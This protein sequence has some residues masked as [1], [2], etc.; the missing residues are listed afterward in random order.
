MNR[1]L[2][3]R[4]WTYLSTAAVA[5][6]L[7]FCPFPSFSQIFVQNELECKFDLGTS[8][9][10][11]AVYPDRKHARYGASYTPAGRLHVLV[12]L[13]NYGQQ[14]LPGLQAWW[15]PA[16][17]NNPN[18]QLIPPSSIYDSPNALFYENPSD[19]GSFSANN[20]L[21]NVSDYY[22]TFSNPNSRFVITGEVFPHVVSVPLSTNHHHPYSIRNA[23]GAALQEM[24]NLEPNY[25]WY[26]FDLRDR[27]RQSDVFEYDN[28]LPGT[29]GEIDMTVLVFRNTG[30][31]ALTYSLNSDSL[32]SP[33]DNKTYRWGIGYSSMKPT[34]NFDNFLNTFTHEF[35]HMNYQAGHQCGANRTHGSRYQISNFYGMMDAGGTGFMTPNAWERWYRGWLSDEILVTPDSVPAAG[36]LYIL[37]DHA[38]DGAAMRIQIPHSNHSNFL[39]YMHDFLW[40]ENHKM[41]HPFDEKRKWNAPDSEPLVPG[42]YA[43]VADNA[44][45]DLDSI[46]LDFAGQYNQ[47]ASNAIH[48]LSAFGKFDFYWNGDSIPEYYS[49]SWPNPR[50]QYILNHTSPNPI[51]GT[52]PR[53]WVS[54]DLNGDGVLAHDR[55]LGRTSAGAL[56]QIENAASTINGNNIAHYRYTG[57]FTEALQPNQEFS[58]S[59]AAPILNY[60]EY[61]DR[62]GTNPAPPNFQAEQ[63]EPYY[64][65]GLQIQHQ[66]F[67]G[68]G[69]AKIFVK[70]NDYEVR[71]STRWTGEIILPDLDSTSTNE[72]MKLAP[73]KTLTLDLSGTP[74]RETIHP[75]TGTW[76]NPT[77]LTLQNGAHLRLGSGSKLIV[78]EF[79]TLKLESGSK[80]ELQAGAEVIVKNGGRLELEDGADLDVSYTGRVHILQSGS[81]YVE[82]Q[83]N[84]HLQ[85]P[86]GVL[87][88]DGAM[89][90]ADSSSF[91]IQPGP[92]GTGEVHWGVA[93]NSPAIVCG[94]NST[95]TITGV[96]VTDPIFR[97]KDNK[98]FQPGS[99]DKL[100]LEY[101]KI[102]MGNQS[103]LSV[104]G[105]DVRMKDLDIHRLNASQPWKTIYING[106]NDHILQYMEITGAETGITGRQFYGQGAILHLQDVNVSDCITGVHVFS[107]GVQMED[108]GLENNDVGLKHDLP[109]RPSRLQNVRMRYNTTYGADIVGATATYKFESC[110]NDY[111]GTDG[112]RF[113]GSANLVLNCGSVKHNASVGINVGL[114]SRVFLDNSYKKTGA[115]MTIVGN[116]VSVLLNY[117]H[118]I[119]FWKG[120]NDLMSAPWFGAQRNIWGNLNWVTANN[121][122]KQ[123]LNNHWNNRTTPCLGEAPIH[124][125]DNIL[126]SANN[127]TIYISDPARHCPPSFCSSGLPGDGQTETFKLAGPPPQGV[128]IQTA[129]FNKVSLPDAVR[130][131]IN[132]M[133]EFT[134]KDD[135]L[136]LAKF[137]E[138]LTYPVPNPTDEEIHFR[139]LAMGHMQSCLQ[140]ALLSGKIPGEKASNDPQLQPWVG[141]VVNAQNAFAASQ[142]EPYM[143]ALCD[144]DLALSYHKVGRNDMSLPKLNAISGVDPN[145]GMTAD[146]QAMLNYSIC[147]IKAQ[148]KVLEGQIDLKDFEAEVAACSGTMKSDQ[149]ELATVEARIRAA[150]GEASDPGAAKLQLYPTPANAQ[151]QFEMSGIRNETSTIRVFNLQGNQLIE[152]TIDPGSRSGSLSL[153]GIPSGLYLMQWQSKDQII[154]QKFEIQ[155]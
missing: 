59:G 130:D 105:A 75:L 23:G 93:A 48:A 85:G 152:Q 67:D 40:L 89:E 41:V 34:N 84:I 31:F 103:W 79:S 56:D 140:N 37:K 10:A 18:P 113:S 55:D 70:Y 99:L 4:L 17:S 123:G 97:I 78:D 53:Q 62:S 30:A 60:P 8:A 134:G 5:F 146:I 88:I 33:L 98:A 65:N 52:T 153:E 21:G 86:G 122:G 68:N 132:D 121:W 148:N 109:T 58:L 38:L 150:E 119:H 1:Q 129:H 145:Y 127:N 3:C 11:T 35:G 50:Y 92:Y 72:Y 100:V 27:K 95:F 44:I 142:Q 49:Q 101:G 16:D 76:A 19:C 155:K 108:C 112:L 69:N 28:T 13:V 90:I 14:D 124:G 36:R 143:Q 147:Q 42:I 74:N 106:Q 154:T 77:R 45:M 7:V 26:K 12:V 96:N 2:D 71:N 107:K 144:M 141:S 54:Q 126:L 82:G 114:N 9:S 137:E 120:Y 61:Y 128:L 73:Y 117:A 20:G 46:P 118:D 24:A 116:Q 110:S 139:D 115:R 111:N 91:V 131:A 51:S 136:A 87:E 133:E 80:L 32:V 104:G 29:D 57:S 6:I 149:N 47:H 25:P 151:L 15:P 66:G 43:Y 125:T 138:I 102:A 39:P 64:L 94:Q 81:F 22:Y 135:L 63:S 83:P